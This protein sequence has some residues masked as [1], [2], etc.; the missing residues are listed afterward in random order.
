MKP[1]VYRL[2]AEIIVLPDG[3]LALSVFDDDRGWRYKATIGESGVALTAEVLPEAM[4]EA[5]LA[6]EHEGIDPLF[7]RTSKRL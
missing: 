2:T 4:A 6:W 3:R 1:G 7:P 5:F